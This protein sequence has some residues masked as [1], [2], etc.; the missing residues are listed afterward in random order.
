MW[1]VESKIFGLTWNKL[2]WTHNRFNTCRLQNGWVFDFCRST[3][4]FGFSFRSGW[5]WFRNHYRFINPII[6]SIGQCVKSCFSRNL[7]WRSFIF[8]KFYFRWGLSCWM[9]WTYKNNWRYKINVVTLNL[10][11]KPQWTCLSHSTKYS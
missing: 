3:G 6:Y 2:I 4:L 8:W 5:K 1:I 7:R 9:I 11:S 10:V